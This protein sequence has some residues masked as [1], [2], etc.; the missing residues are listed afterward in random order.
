MAAINALLFFI[1]MFSC[2]VVLR[3]LLSYTFDIILGETHKV[4]PKRV[5]FFGLALAYVL[6]MI[7]GKN[8]TF[9][10]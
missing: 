1:F 4:T 3:E 9:I 6:T 8:F 2:L 10:S 7:F 5:L